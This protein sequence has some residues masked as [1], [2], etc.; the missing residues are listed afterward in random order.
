MDAEIAGLIALNQQLIED[1]LGN[2]A[3]VGVVDF[4]DRGTRLDLDPATDGVQ[5]TTTPNADNDNNGILDVEEALASLND[6]GNT[7]F[8]NAL[9]ASEQSFIDL[10]TQPGNGNL[11]FLSDGEDNRNLDDELERLDN[12][13]INISAFGVGE[14]ASIESLE[15]IDSD[16]VIFTSTDELLAAFGGVPQSGDSGESESSIEPGLDG[17]TIYLDLNNNGE[18]DDNEPSQVSNENGEYSFAGLEAGTYIVREVVPDNSTQ[19]A[20]EDGKFSIELEESEVFEGAN[21]G[22]T[23]TVG[24]PIETPDNS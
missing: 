13:G 9:E 16:A 10:G 3:N 6:G 21:F 12:L 17:V 19:T 15:A 2:T 11:I 4:S 1:G 14:D 5:L 24:E 18:L 8:R 23:N 20:P 7:N 22:N